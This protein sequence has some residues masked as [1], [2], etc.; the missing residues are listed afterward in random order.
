MTSASPA[1]RFF[2]YFRLA[3]AVGLAVLFF[4]RQ[5]PAASVRTHKLHVAEDLWCTPVLNGYAR[6]TR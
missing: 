3:L 4:S 6:Q 1:L 5:G 2:F